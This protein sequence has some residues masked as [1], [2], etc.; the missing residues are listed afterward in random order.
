LK[1]GENIIE[2][3][4]TEIGNIPFSCSMGMYTG[5]ITVVEK[6]EES[7][8]T[9]D[10]SGNTNQKNVEVVSGGSC[11]TSNGGSGGCGMMKGAA[12]LET[13]AVPVSENGPQGSVQVIKTSYTLSD[14]IVPNTFTVRAGSPVRL[15]VDVK[16]NGEGCMS[17]I[18]IPGLS[19]SAQYLEKGKKI[20]MEFTPVKSGSYKITCA[21][22]VPRGTI[23]VE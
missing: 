22:G 2:F 13:K 6:K 19:N 14:D 12:Q 1:I 3:T 15:E 23:T 18:M 7:G 9:G 8:A 21:M 17:S 20:A 11:M 10:T 16:E 4:P 5:T